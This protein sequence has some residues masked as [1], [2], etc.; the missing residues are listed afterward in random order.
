[1]SESVLCTIANKVSGEAQQ[2]GCVFI[3]G[4]VGGKPSITPP[5]VTVYTQ[6]EQSQLSPFK[7]E[8]QTYV[9]LP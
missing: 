3:T 2:R 6:K 5:C 4:Q 8:D 7:Y 1:M 9:P